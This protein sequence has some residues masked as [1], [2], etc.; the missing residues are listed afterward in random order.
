MRMPTRCDA[1]LDLVLTNS[2]H[3]VSDLISGPGLSISDHNT[4]EFTVSCQQHHK[5]QHAKVVHNYNQADFDAFREALSRT[6]WETIFLGDD[7]IDI[8]WENWISLFEMTVQGVIPTKKLKRRN[9][10]P[11]VIGEIHKQI[12]RKRHFWKVARDKGSPSAWA[13]HKKLTK[14]LKSELFRAYHQNG[15]PIQ[16]Q[17]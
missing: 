8:V 17:S 9:H 5:V 13:K 2:P 3:S 16:V 11:W 6:P 14:W 15:Y 10:L 4:V 12:R 7:D 1:L